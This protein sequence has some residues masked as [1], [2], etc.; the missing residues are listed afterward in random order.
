MNCVA[1]IRVSS[2]RQANEDRTS[3]AD[4]RGAVE[5]LAARLSRVVGTVF[6]DAGIS[7]STA[8]K[9][10]GFMA[11]VTYCEAHPRTDG[12]VLVLNQSRFGRFPDPDD[13]AYW[14]TRL[15]QAG[16][17]V[18]Y[19]E[20]D[21]AEQVTTRHLMRAIGDAGASEYRATLQANIRRGQKGT[22]EQG[23]WA[24]RA[25]FG[26]ARQVVG[27]GEILRDGQ[28]K[29]D[30]ERV[31]LVPNEHAALVRQMFAR[32]ARG[33]ESL[34]SLGRWMAERSEDR[35]WHHVGQ[36]R[37]MLG[38]RT[39][40]GEID[41]A[42]VVHTGAHEPLVGPDVFARVAERLEENQRHTRRIA[43]DYALSGVLRCAV[44]G[45]HFIGGGWRGGGTERRPYYVDA[46]SRHG[47]TCPG[48]AAYLNK[49]KVEGIV[50]ERFASQLAQ[51]S[52]LDRIQER[53]E[54]LVSA[55]RGASSAQVIA[56]R[57]SALGRERARLVTA[58]GKGIV[59][60]A[61]VARRLEEIR[62]ESERLTTPPPAPPLRVEQAVA[63]AKDFPR[64]VSLAT[65]N[66]LRHLL[67]DWL[68]RLV[69][70][71][72]S[73]VLTIGI[74]RVPSAF[75]KSAPANELSAHKPFLIRVRV[76]RCA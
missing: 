13:A 63:L 65:G 49:A 24:T 25:P 55:R 2:E 69:Y 73:R 64:A 48:K 21:D 6:T 54:A 74:N 17:V 16:W 76:G 36:M 28:A 57:L 71:K 61:D 62:R 7:G 15:R 60:E 41:T 9:R 37:W 32:Y 39:Y 8:E 75:L 10:P 22:A 38:N 67:E 70:D 20:N 51:S 68:D 47:N 35:Q 45:H 52:V 18:R 33:T 23:Y 4:Q 27:S 44:C 40:L 56:T 26:Y 5:V 42:G 53:V 1:Y 59:G 12:L 46:G 30:A 29:R 14:R 11:L 50:V 34:A 31:K 66:E 3:L 43:A 58:L 19:A 72:R